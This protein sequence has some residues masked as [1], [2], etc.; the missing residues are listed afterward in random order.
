MTTVV[1]FLQYLQRLWSDVVNV[2]KGKTFQAVCD[3]Y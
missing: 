2:C 1:P 3:H